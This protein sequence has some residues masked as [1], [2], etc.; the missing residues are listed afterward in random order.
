MTFDF[1]NAAA[2]EEAMPRYNDGQEPKVPTVEE[3]TNAISAAKSRLND[4]KPL[5]AEFDRLVENAVAQMLESKP[6][7]TSSERKQCRREATIAIIRNSD[8]FKPANFKSAIKPAELPLWGFRIPSHASPKASR[9]VQQKLAAADD[10]QIETMVESEPVLATVRNLRDEELRMAQ[11]MLDVPA[12]MEADMK[13]IVRWV[14]EHLKISLSSI[15]A[16]TIP[17]R[18]ALVLLEDCRADADFRRSLLTKWMDKLMPTK[19]QV[20]YEAQFA[21]D[22]RKSLSLVERTI[23]NIAEPIE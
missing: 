13:T 21:D 15:Q 17:C 20:E 12:G 2:M 6:G 14:I 19:T 22:G 9:K 1:T 10:A 7:M 8:Q 18:A 23:R 16:D 5:Y 11:L 3:L 4:N